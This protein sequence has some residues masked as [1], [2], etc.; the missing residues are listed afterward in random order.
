MFKSIDYPLKN[1]YYKHLWFCLVL[2]I[3]LILFFI[4]E[5]I[6]TDTYWVSYLP[7]DDMIP[8]NEIFVIAYVFWYP[9]MV[10]MGLYL[11]YRNSGD[12]CRYMT[13]I[14]VGFISS[15]IFCVLFPNGQNLRPDTFPRNN[16][17]TLI[18]SEIYKADTNTNVLPSM[19]VIGSMAVIFATFNCKGLKRKKFVRFF[20]I[21][22]GLLISVSTVFVKQHSILDIIVALPWAAVVY[23]IVYLPY[24]IKEHKLKKLKL[25][26]YQPKKEKITV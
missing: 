21:F 16:I 24:N 11:I 15:L 7:I 22:M 17:F 1:K 13:F 9:F 18:L 4:A 25:K 2:P 8:F 6:V 20:V 26:S 5:H 12:F 23:A 14:A 10:V 3:Y 19:H